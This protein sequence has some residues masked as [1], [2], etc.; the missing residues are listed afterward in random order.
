MSGFRPFK[1]KA[2]L[3][4]VILLLAGHFLVLQRTDDS[5]EEFLRVRG[6]SVEYVRMAEADGSA[7]TPFRYRPL[8][9]SLV[10][11]LPLE[12]S[13]GF[14]VVSYL[15]LFLCFVVLFHVLEGFGLGPWT[16]RSGLLLLFFSEATLYQFHNPF[17]S[18]AA[19]LLFL[20]LVL[21]AAYE[22]RLVLFG[23]AAAAGLL[24][25]EATLFAVPAYLSTRQFRPFAVVLLVLLGIFLVPRL[26]LQAPDTAEGYFAGY[27][28]SAAE[29]GRLEEP[30]GYLKSAFFTWDFLWLSALLGLFVMQTGRSLLLL[31]LVSL[32]CGAFL[33]GLVATDLNRMFS[34][35]APPLVCLSAVCLG[36][37]KER[38]LLVW[39][40]VIGFLAWRALFSVPTVINPSAYALAGSVTGR[41]LVLGLSL[42]LFLLCAFVLRKD[43]RA[44]FSPGRDSPA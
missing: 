25:R 24:C 11:L 38:S 12:V 40:V 39:S 14:V 16:M 19:G 6:D 8:V 2:V 33:S 35:L 43:V 42:L 28:R 20:F 34:L 7:P 29:L 23:T 27:F 30:F 10:S 21:L 17:L 44:A 18:D 32:G 26:L 37:V 5:A 4:A 22:H 41:R 1:A 13:T 31:A 15:A 36:R 9:P 3:V